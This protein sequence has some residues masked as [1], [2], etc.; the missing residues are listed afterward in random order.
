MHGLKQN[1]ERE[2]RMGVTIQTTEQIKCKNCGSTAVVKFGT[3]K[4][5]QRGKG[6]R[7]IAKGRRGRGMIL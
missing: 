3:Y 5:V 2:N 1:K 6:T 7:L 4:G